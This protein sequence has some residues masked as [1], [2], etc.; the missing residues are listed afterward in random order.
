MPGGRGRVVAMSAVGARAQR[1]CQHPAHREHNGRRGPPRRSGAW[2][3]AAPRSRRTPPPCWRRGSRPGPPP[4]CCTGSRAS[5]GPCGTPAWGWTARWRWCCPT[6]GRW[7]SPSP[8]RHLGGA[9]RRSIPRSVTEVGRP[10]DLRA[11]AVVLAEGVDGPARQAAAELGVVQLELSADGDRPGDDGARGRRSGPDD[12]A[13]LLHLGDDGSAEDGAAHP[14]QHPGVGRQRGPHPRPHRRGPVPQPHA[15]VP[16]PRAGGLPHR[17]PVGGR[18]GRLHAGVRPGRRRPLGRGGRPTWYSAVPT[19]HQAMVAAVPGGR[20]WGLRFI[21]SSSAA[22]PPQL[23]ARLEAT[24]DV[25]VVEAYRMTSPPD[26]QRPLAAGSAQARH[27]GP[28]PAGPEVIVR[29]REICIRGPNVTAGYLDNPEAN[30]TPP[31]RVTA[32]C[33]RATRGALDE[34]GYLTAPRR[35]PEG[36]STGVGRR[37]LPGRSR[38]CSTMPPWRRPS[39]SPCPTRPWARTWPPPSCCGPMPGRSRLRRFAAGRLGARKAAAAARGGRRPPRGRTGSS[40][41]WPRRSA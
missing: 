40:G 16:H 41:K 18:V 17:Q 4:T 19:I 23:L 39:P 2:S 9:L 7:R 28:L 6:G 1:P 25:P 22:L 11:A 8:R 27:R 21:R 37:S 33:A 5:R 32:G 35:P 13:L 34:D 29:D 31:S 36:S 10:H 30:A 26:R 38:R 3:S 14:R 12:I 15:A 24:F 20:D